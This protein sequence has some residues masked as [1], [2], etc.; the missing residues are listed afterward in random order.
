MDQTPI[1]FEFLD[2]KTY[3]TIGTR[4]VFVK[5]TDSGWDWRQATLQILVRADG[6]QRCKPLLI[7]YGM[8]EDRRQKPKAGN[9]RREYRLYYSRVEVGLSLIL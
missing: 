2:N 5:Q 7:F 6:I 4:T 1:S 8:N 3:D 9:L